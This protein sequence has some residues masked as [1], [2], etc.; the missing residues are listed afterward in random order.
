[1]PAGPGRDDDGALLF[2][3]QRGERLGF[4]LRQRTLL[5]RLTLAVEAI[6]L[7]GDARRLHAVLLEQ[8]PRAEIGTTDAA[9]GIDARPEQKAEV[10]R[11]RRPGE[12][13]GIH[14]R[15]EADAV[16]AAHGDQPLGDEGTVEA[17]QGHH[18]GNGAQRD[19][20]EQRH[21]VGLGAVAGP[22]AAGTQLAVHRHDR[23]ERQAHRGEMAEPGEIIEPV[24][25]DHRDRRR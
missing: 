19:E 17:L 3:A 7:G 2:E 5:D 11:L 15:G 21:Q 18:V 22:E 1:M 14:Q 8:E 16:A 13:R 9:A 4:G 20:I 10:P 25:I 12:A 24:G 23:E 6:K